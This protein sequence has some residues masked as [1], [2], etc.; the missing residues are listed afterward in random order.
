M[1]IIM[2]LSVLKSETLL[3]RSFGTK[4]AGRFQVLRRRSVLS[5][6][7]EDARPT[8]QWPRLERGDIVDDDALPE[9]LAG[10]NKSCVVLA[11]GLVKLVIL[12]RFEVQG[13]RKVE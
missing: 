10:G 12:K 4:S 9:C 11:L 5:A 13:G 3:W 6:A 1:S 7:R 2:F 8:R